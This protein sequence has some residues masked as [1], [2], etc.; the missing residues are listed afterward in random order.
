MIVQEAEGKKEA[1]LSQVHKFE[2]ERL[3]LLQ[4]LLPALPT[5]VFSGFGISYISSDISHSPQSAVSEFSYLLQYLVNKEVDLVRGEDAEC[6]KPPKKCLHYPMA[7]H[8]RNLVSLR[9]VTIH[10]TNQHE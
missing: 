7:N 2:N 10:C 4:K 8:Q 6:G 9:K 1:R 3:V 5:A